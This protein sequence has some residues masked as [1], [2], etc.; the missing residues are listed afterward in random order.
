M[1]GLVTQRP[2]VQRL[3]ARRIVGES[4]ALTKARRTNLHPPE[5]TWWRQ[6]V[7]PRGG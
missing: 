3:D 6:A 1:Q 4:S 5:Q 2:P 7:E